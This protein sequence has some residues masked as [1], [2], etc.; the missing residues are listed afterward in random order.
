MLVKAEWVA[1]AVAVRLWW[2]RSRWSHRGPRP[3]LHRLQLVVRDERQHVLAL[4][5]ALERLAEARAAV[6]RMT[7]SAPTT[8]APL[9]SLNAY[10]NARIPDSRAG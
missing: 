4:L 9:Q 5:L 1:V 7:S 8:D 6:V 2:R 10:P 3:L